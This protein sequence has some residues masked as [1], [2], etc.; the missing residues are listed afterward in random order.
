MK[1]PT[2]VHLAGVLEL[3]IFQ[4]PS[5]YNRRISAE[6]FRDYIQRMHDSHHTPKERMHNPASASVDY[7]NV[8]QRRCYRR[9]LSI[10]DL[11]KR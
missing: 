10:S 7:P 5:T 6:Q 11:E 4:K 3:V 2:L 8:G 1:H 9:P